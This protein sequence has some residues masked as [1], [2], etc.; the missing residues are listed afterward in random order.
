M[1]ACVSV[2][3]RACSCVFVRRVTSWSFRFTGCPFE[4]QWGPGELGFAAGLSKSSV[5]LLIFSSS[6]ADVVFTFTSE[7]TLSSGG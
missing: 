7:A 4:G 1:F 5:A 6:G 2:F 3:V